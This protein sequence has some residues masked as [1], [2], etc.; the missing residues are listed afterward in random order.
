[1]R[2][3]DGKRFNDLPGDEVFFHLLRCPHCRD[4]ALAQFGV[5]KADAAPPPPAPRRKKP[6]V[7][8]EAEWLF[9]GL[10]RLSP[11]KRTEAAKDPRYHRADLLDLILEKS[12]AAQAEDVNRAA[13]LAWL[14]VSLATNIDADDVGLRKHLVRA[15]CLA[16]NPRRMAG[17][18]SAAESAFDN[19]SFFLSDEP[20]ERGLYCRAL[21]LL[22]W[23]QGRL[24][25]AAALLRYAACAYGEKEDSVEEG[26]CL[27]LLGLLYTEA[28]EFF[29]AIVPLLRA[30]LALVPTRRHDWLLA[31][32]HLS[33][34]LCLAEEGRLAEAALATLDLAVFYEE[35]GRRG[36]VERLIAELEAGSQGLG[37][38]DVALEVLRGFASEHL[39]GTDPRQRAR[40]YSRELRQTFR[41]RNLRSGALPWI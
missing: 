17:D 2:E 9:D 11:K 37:G 4:M 32:S 25:E 31:R 22:R 30:Q 28:E 20:P 12:E 1:M 27:A 3:Y 41:L 14:A 5:H 34:L 23:D 15:F 21:A 36:E 7:R 8:K 13:E 18:R 33:L 10:M 6:V 26:A 29:P 35:S 16:G 38:S 24:D 19:A 39:K 40:M